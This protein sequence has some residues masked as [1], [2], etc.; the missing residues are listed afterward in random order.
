MRDLISEISRIR[1]MMNLPNN[2]LTEAISIPSGFYEFIE[3]ILNRDAN[4]TTFTFG[5]LRNVTRQ[6]LK[7]LVTKLQSV[8]FEI[9]DLNPKEKSIIGNIIG[10]DPDMSKRFYAEFITQEMNRNNFENET[11]F[12][13]D[14]QSK[15]KD[16]KYTG[17]DSSEII[18][19][20]YGSIPNKE[21]ILPAI[22]PTFVKQLD[23]LRTTPASFTSVLVSG[24]VKI[25]NKRQKA[26]IIKVINGKSASVFA[27][28]FIKYFKNSVDEIK[29]EIEG[30]NNGYLSEV[31]KATATSTDSKTLDSTLNSLKEA[32]A[33]KIASLMNQLEIRTNGAAAD[34]LNNYGLDSNITA[35]I[36]S[37]SYEF[38]TMFR[39]IWE[40]EG[41]SLVTM[42]KDTNISFLNEFVAL[43]KQLITKEGFFK[44][45]GSL[46]NPRT[47]I[48]QFMLTSQFASIN[49]QYLA[50]IRTSALENKSNKFKFSQLYLTQSFIGY[51]VGFLIYEVL[52]LLWELGESLIYVAR[53]GI[54]TSKF[55]Q[56]W[57]G[58]DPPD[59]PE[60]IYLDLK[61]LDN[62]WIKFKDMFSILSGFETSGF[63]GVVVMVFET[64][65][66]LIPGGFGTIR[67]SIVW[68][69]LNSTLSTA[70]DGKW[71]PDIVIENFGNIISTEIGIALETIG[72]AEVTAYRDN[73]DSFKK[74]LKDQK[75]G[76]KYDIEKSAK[77]K[78]LDGEWYVAK[79]KGDETDLYYQF[80]DNN[81]VIPQ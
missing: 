66:T 18:D 58:T 47:S 28:D 6:E 43:F 11:A 3:K 55:W 4:E 10:S 63:K 38:F 9:K 39:G 54:T 49:K 73:L 15:A 27:G 76:D 53:R 32:Y 40:K 35:I 45:I 71:S 25:L 14:F 52:F 74:F 23:V 24:S 78:D 50:L 79:G 29:L 12:L 2:L 13:R 21:L 41:E 7:D 30:F 17:M 26:K 19:K 42:I 31:E 37:D 36:R 5:S 48:G 20:I 72:V 70:H 60:N 34:V 67:D 16:K 56:K 80:K 62:L 68:D 61:F 8:D 1:E 22:R 75:M 77:E 69:G 51:Y 46:I 33:G 65:R 81:F 44:A 64:I 57:I 59:K